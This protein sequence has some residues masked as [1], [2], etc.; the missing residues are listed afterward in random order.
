MVFWR[1]FVCVFCLFVLIFSFFTVFNVGGQVDNVWLEVEV[2]R[3]YVVHG[4]SF[5]LTVY[6]NFSGSCDVSFWLGG[7]RVGQVLS[8]VAN[9]S[10]VIDVLESY[11]Y[12]EYVVRGVYGGVV[13]ETWLT[14][15]D[16]SGWVSVGFPY[17]R[18][19]K[20]INYTFYRSGVVE[21]VS[22]GSG[23]VML[24]DL[25]TV[26]GLVVE[27]GL[28][29]D[30]FVNDMGFRVRFSKGSLVCVD[31][32]F[33]FVHSGCKFVV[34]GT[35][36]RD[37]VF[38][39]DV[40]QPVRL[41]SF[42]DGFGVGGVCFGY[43]DLRL[44]DYDFVYSNGVLSLSLPR[45]FSFDPTIFSDGFES[46]DFSV[47]TTAN[48][49]P[50][51]VESP[52]HHGSYSAK[53]T[54]FYGNTIIKE[55]TPASTGYARTY[56]YITTLPSLSEG[57]YYNIFYFGEDSGPSVQICHNG[58]G[59]YFALHDN[60]WGSGNFYSDVEVSSSVWYCIEIYYRQYSATCQLF[61][62]DVLE[63]EMNGPASQ[64][65]D[66]IWIG[67]GGGGD[68]GSFEFEWDCVVVADE[69]I[70][71]EAE[72]ANSISL[73]LNSPADDSTVTDS[74]TQTFNY[75]PV[76]VGSDGFYNSSLYVNGSLVVSNSSVI[77]NNTA[78]FLNY[79]FGGNGV[80]LWDV[81][82]FNSTDSVF[83]GNGNFT[84][85]VNYT[86]PSASGYDEEYV[87]AVYGVAFLGFV[88][89]LVAFV[90][91]VSIRVYNRGRI[92]RRR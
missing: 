8:R 12:G 52:V 75:T 88:L 16:I 22:V 34:N 33:A 11:P 27:Y 84:L 70:G 9:S 42:V 58:T 3:V 21:C 28:D 72:E 68:Y 10:L 61:I 17:N 30:A 40:G 55:L 46:G 49:S 91:V 44:V 86:A 78:N 18:E 25:S 1:R 77:A 54:G 7:V 50:A 85:T 89:A 23:D 2:D 90:L 69:Y 59:V 53:V 65:Y 20:G 35:L 14:V 36:D 39:F 56:F 74:L 43:G 66:C 38:N 5:Y 29:V 73:T 51:V 80:Y 45:Y 79:T 60:Y 26:R 41:R 82:L 63:A 48:G 92:Y 37:R 87:D 32:L 13:C 64:D 67:C 57:E 47:W 15:L 62:D 83:G 71:L 76:V 19:F 81:L 24:V 6:G 4:D 31:F